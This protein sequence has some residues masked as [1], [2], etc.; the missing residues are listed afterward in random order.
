MVQTNLITY[1]YHKYAF[2]IVAFILV[3]VAF[4]IWIQEVNEFI[5]YVLLGLVLFLVLLHF[6]FCDPI[7][8]VRMNSISIEFGGQSINWGEVDSVDINWF[9]IYK[10]TVKGSD[11]TLFFVGSDGGEFT[12]LA[13]S[14][15]ESEMYTLVKE[16][17]LKHGFGL[18]PL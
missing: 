16:M 1:F 14:E 12:F 2:L 15:G 4:K 3:G 7:R 18:N 11:Q 8:R 13:A 6:A 9:G 5:P 10:L 17:H